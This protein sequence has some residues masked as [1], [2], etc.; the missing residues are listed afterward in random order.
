MHAL[1]I[2]S[3]SSSVKY[4]LFVMPGEKLLASGRVENIGV[5]NSGGRALLVQQREGCPEF[6]ENFPC[7]DHEAAIYRVF[8]LLVSDTEGVLGAVGE[9]DVVGH[10]VVHGGSRFLAPTVITD[11][12]LEALSEL[13][14]LAPLHIPLNVMCIRACRRMA[15]DVPMAA[16]FDTAFSHDTPPHVHIYPVPMQWHDVYGIRRYGFHGISYAY[17]AAEAAELLGLAPEETKLIA[18]HL[19]NGS[20]IMAWDRGRVLDTS[21]GFTPL[22]GLM[23][24]TRSGD[25][26][27]AI[28]PFIMEKTGMSVEAILK[29]LNT[30]SGLLGIS[31]VSR[32]MREIVGEMDAGNQRAR[33]AF[34]MFVHILRKYIGGYYFNLGGADAIAFTG[35]IGENAHRVREAVFAPLAGLGLKL[36]PSKNRAAV[37]GKAGVI[38]SEESRTRVLVIP[39]DEERMIAR[40]VFALAAGAGAG[41][42][43]PDGRAC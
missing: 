32:D 1:V 34:D 4:K 17:A 27:P 21:M 40:S 39:A 10:R 25:F 19:G 5:G 29:A 7:R 3:G 16:C 14:E 41:A 35:G 43:L 8:D 36:D 24:G 13:T 12:V 23:M 30:G 31:G 37:G 22:E 18:T 38:S 9:I 33:L 20:S 11:E 15:P 28:F 2:N 42:C 6:R 26:D